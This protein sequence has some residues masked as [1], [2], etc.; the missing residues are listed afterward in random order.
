MVLAYHLIWVAYGWWLPN[1]LRGSMSRGIASDVI[2]DLGALHYG[3]KKI[4]PASLDI[5]AFYER[6]K[7]PPASP[8]GPP[9][10][11]RT[12]AMR[13]NDTGGQA[14]VAPVPPVAPNLPVAPELHQ[15]GQ[16]M[17]TTVAGSVGFCVGTIN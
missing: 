13:S 3:R 5:R 6:A 2:A 16:S 8:L 10:N 4:Q 12:I 1:D 11:N 14:P 17:T 9:A 7:E 15:V